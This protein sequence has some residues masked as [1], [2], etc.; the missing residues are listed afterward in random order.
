MSS[1][2]LAGLYAMW[3]P[4]LDPRFIALNP[5]GWNTLLHA[6]Q[7]FLCAVPQ[8]GR[9][10]RATMRRGIAQRKRLNEAALRGRGRR[11]MGSDSAG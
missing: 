3:S 7:R 5:G 1:A 11:A 10:A 4:A 2:P 6:M 8:Q 9:R